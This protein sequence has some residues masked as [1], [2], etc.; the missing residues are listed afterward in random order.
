MSTKSFGAV[1]CG[2]LLLAVAS[3]NAQ[4]GFFLSTTTRADLGGLDFLDGD[5]AEYDPLSDFGTL[6]FKESSFLFN[7]EVDAYSELASGDMFFS[8]SEDGI[9]GGLQFRDGDVVRY[10]PRTGRASLFFSESTFMLNEDIDALDVLDNGNILLSTKEIAEIGGISIHPCDVAEYDPRTDKAFLRI[11][12]S[13]IFGKDVNLDAIQQVGDNQFLLSTGSQT[14]VGDVL[15]ENEDLVQV[16]LD[17][18]KADLF[19][20]GSQH[21]LADE[22]ID[23]VSLVTKPVP[24]PSSLLLMGVGFVGVAL[25]QRKRLRGH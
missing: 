11:K 2:C 9:L 25:T 8:T 16:D 18:K 6:H 4:A 17:T 20:D 14:T 3:G 1:W 10:D 12:G 13:D 21:F 22:N 24:E 15:V 5:I 7:V 19:F 23:A